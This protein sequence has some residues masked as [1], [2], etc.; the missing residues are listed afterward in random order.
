MFFGKLPEYAKARSPEELR[1]NGSSGR[2]WNIGIGGVPSVGK[3]C[4]NG[5]VMI[6]ESE[7]LVE[8]PVLAKCGTKTNWTNSWW[9]ENSY[10]CV[11]IGEW[12]MGG[13][14]GLIWINWKSVGQMQIQSRL[15]E[16][17][18]NFSGTITRIENCLERKTHGLIMPPLFFIVFPSNQTCTNTSIFW[19][20]IFHF[21]LRFVNHV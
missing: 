12:G 7:T 8:C 13:A 14:L 21:H 15:S 10:C 3:I 6:V 19:V 20:A 17:F 16:W 2:I 5:I 9:F 11:L 1:L 4:G 18:A